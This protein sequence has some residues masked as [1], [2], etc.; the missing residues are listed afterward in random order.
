MIPPVKPGSHAMHG[1]DEGAAVRILEI[2][3]RTI[4]KYT[5]DVFAN[6]GGGIVVTSL[7]AINYRGN[8]FEQGGETFARGSGSLFYLFPSRDIAPGSDD[9]YWLALFVTNHALFVTHPAI[10]A[11][12]AAETVFE[13]VLPV[14]EL[15][16]NLALYTLK[17]VRMYPLAPEI[18]V[19]KIFVWGVAE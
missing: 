13:H 8:G 12:L 5:L 16:R 4:T 6:K 18:C 9:F 2:V 14:L 10:G 3:V 17:I 19:L 1:A 15:T 11:V 7:E